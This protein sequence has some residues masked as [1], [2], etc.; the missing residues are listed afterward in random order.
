MK[1]GGLPDFPHPLW[2]QQYVKR[3][4]E[5]QHEPIGFSACLERLCPPPC[6]GNPSHPEEFFFCTDVACQVALEFIESW[7]VLFRVMRLYQFSCDTVYS[8]IF[9]ISHF[10]IYSLWSVKSPRLPNHHGRSNPHEI[11]I[12]CGKS[13]WIS[14]LSLFFGGLAE[15][16]GGDLVYATCSLC[17]RQNE[18][19]AKSSMYSNK[20]Q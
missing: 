8:C 16:Q 17:Q 14:K 2:Q 15:H 6:F 9:I 4:G 18:D 12:Y 20:E 3:Q 1:F 7:K 13:S 5:R 19:V 10:S 11:T